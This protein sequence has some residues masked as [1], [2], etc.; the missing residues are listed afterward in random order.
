MTDA[1]SRA[2]ELMQRLQREQCY[3]I[4]MR[5]AKDPPPPPRPQ[6]ELRLEHHAFLVEMERRGVLFA[7]GPCRDAEGGVRGAG[8]LIF[9][10]ASRA[11]AE[12]LAREEPYTKC[13]QREIEIIPWQRNEGAMELHLRL[14]DG[15]LEIDHRRWRIGPVEE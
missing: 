1:E 8:L 15:I 10:A 6:A 2:A 11:E 3:L 7:A 14:A 5:P 12:A 13:G 9:R 4:M